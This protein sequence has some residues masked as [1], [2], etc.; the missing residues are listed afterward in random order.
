MPQATDKDT[1]FD[2]LGSRI[3]Q[4]KGVVNAI[5]N[6]HDD[7]FGYMMPDPYMHNAL[8]AVVELIDQAQAAFHAHVDEGLAKKAK[9]MPE[10]GAQ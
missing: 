5:Q 10:G 1:P 6:T 4:L 7:E 8:W 3:A 2:V 9:Q